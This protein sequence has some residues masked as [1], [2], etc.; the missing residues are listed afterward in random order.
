MIQPLGKRTVA[1]I[2]DVVEALF[3]R[4]R[5]RLLGRKYLPR[6]VLFGPTAPPVEH[7][8]D[9]SLP[10]I[11]DAAARG[12]GFKPREDVRESAMRAA[13]TYLDAYKERTKAAAVEA[14]EA[15]LHESSEHGHG[16][17]EKAMSAMK[18]R[19]A[20][21]ISSATAEVK[22]LVESESTAAKNVGALDGLVKVNILAGVSDPVVYF[23]SVNDKNRCKTCTRLHTVD[24]ASMPRL[25]R[26]S[27]VA[28]GYIKHDSPVPSI[29]GA[30]PRCRCS[31]VSLLPDWGLNAAGMPEYRHKGYDAF[32]EQRGPIAR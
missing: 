1:S 30:H 15:A 29:K 17:P 24:G 32:A 8:D 11:F 3:A 19:I 9:L 18:G 12:E 2:H 22:R 14:V 6:R 28:R 23:V 27:E 4:A 13:A 7:R 10:G 20:D 25:W 16:S 5:V 31:M 26:L 21:A